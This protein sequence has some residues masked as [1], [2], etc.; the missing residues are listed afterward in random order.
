VIDI[1]F[2][3]ELLLRDGS[4]CEPAETPSFYLNFDGVLTPYARPS[5]PKCI[6]CGEQ[7]VCIGLDDCMN[8]EAFACNDCCDH[9][10]CRFLCVTCSA[11]VPDLQEGE[12]CETCVDRWTP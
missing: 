9:G 6:T 5:I 12:S 4:A 7:A 1:A 11:D 8:D 2:E 3:R 10:S